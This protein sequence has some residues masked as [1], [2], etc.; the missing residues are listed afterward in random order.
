MTEGLEKLKGSRKAY[1]SHLTRIYGKLED[2]DLTK[3]PNDDTTAT[4]KSYIEQLQR[5]AESIQAIDGKI[6][7]IMEDPSEIE[8]DVLDS[9]EIQDTLIERIT[10]LK[11]YLEKTKVTTVT[12]P[13]P[14]T[15]ETT[16]RSVTASRLPKL[17][18]PKYSG[19]PLGWQTFWDSFR[20]AVHSSTHLTGI[21]KFNYLR[22]QLEGEA[23]R[24]INGLTL[25][26]DNYEQAVK[27]LESRFGKKQRIINAHMQA[28]T[29]LPTPSNSATS[30]R[31]LYDTLESHIRGLEALGKSKDTF[32]DFLIPIIF[33]RLP[34]AV[35]RNLTRDHTSEE[36][37]I[38]ELR[39]AIEKEITVLESGLDSQGDSSRST[40]SGTFLAGVR[41]GHSGQH[42]LGDKRIVSAKPV[43]VYCKGPHSSAQC[44]VVVDVKARLDV[45]KREKLCFNCLGSHRAMYCNSKNRCRLCHKK[46][47]TSLCGM[48]NP[49]ISGP[50]QQTQ[51]PQTSQP[52]QDTPI[53]SQAPQSSLNPASNSF[54]P[55]QPVAN[56]TTTAQPLL[57][58][59]HSPQ[60]LL[61][62]AI[63]LVRFGN[64][65]ISANILFDEGAQRSFVTETLASRLDA[66]PHR[67]ENL[68]IS[69][70]G[71]STSRNNQVSLINFVLETTQ[72]DVK[73]S[74]LVV[75][76]I[77]APIQ[78][79]VNS[80]LRN[81]AHLQ[82]LTLAHPVSSIEK[83]EIS[84][85]IG[86]D[87]Y[88]EI[89]GNHIVR[90]RGPTAMQSKLGYLLSGPLSAPPESITG[91]VHSYTT[92]T[93]DL[94][95]S[96]CPELLMNNCSPSCTLPQ[97]EV[98]SSEPPQSF[99]LTYQE[100][101]I[102]RDTDG[103]YIV[104]F[105]WKETHPLLPSNLAI[106]DRQTRA[107][108]RRL[109][110]QP[111]LLQLYGSIISDQEQ[112]N[113]IERAP[114]QST[115]GVHYIPHHPVRKDSPTT[116]VRIVYNC[117]CRQSPRHAS[118][119]DCLMVGDSTL[120]D[121]C[122]ILLR[123]RLHCY[124]ISTDIEKAFLHV[125]LDSR[126]RDFTRFLWLAD[127]T[128]PESPFV[129][130]RFK[131]V[132][133]GSVS[134]PFM[135]NATLDLH[136][137]SFDSPVSRDMKNNLYVDNI[138]SGCQSEK[139]ILQYYNESRAIMSGAKF[140]LRSWASNSSKLQ[141]Q[142]HKD[143]TLDADTTVNL[144][145]LKWNTC[146][147]TIYLSQC[148]ITHSPVT[149][150]SILQASSKQYDPLG[151]L[152]PITVRA[153]LLIQELW[154]RQVGWDEPLDDE[155]T[156]R[157]SQ[158]A[159]DIEAVAGIVMSRRYSVMCTDQCV[160]LHVFADAS[161]KAYGAVAYLQSAEQVDLVM[162]K[163]RVSPLKST[164]LPRLELRATVIAAHLAKYIISTIQPQ[165]NEVNIRLWSDSQITL[166]WIFSSKQLQPFV[167]NRVQEIRS[168][169]PVSVWGYCNTDDN[170]ADLLTRGITPS[171]LQSS[172]LW[173]R[174]PAWLSS[175][176]D[177][178]KWSPTS[179]LHISTDEDVEPTIPVLEIT[180]ENK[181]GV[182][183]CIDINRYSKLHKL[184]RVT[185][186]V[187]RFVNNLKAASSKVTGPLTAKELNQSQKLWIT[188]TQQEI[189]SNELI[190][191]QSSLSPRLP[192]VRQLRLYLNKEGII[193]CGGRI[194]NA[195]V[196]HSAK[197]P[198]LLPRKHKFTELIVRDAH[199]KHFHTGTNSTVTYIRQR[200]WIPAARQCVK[201]ILRHCVVCNK[202]CGN[203]YKAPNPPPLP[204]HRV[205]M[206]EPFTVTGID[207][208]GALYIR[209][210]EG[211]NKVYICL[212]TCA[213]TRAVHLEVVTDLSEETFLQAFR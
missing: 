19:D 161:M 30:L 22:G 59:K 187:L 173:F 183:Q 106:C 162:A 8:G 191:I 26:N 211:E 133:F 189:F 122:A 184:Y 194:H 104:R 166:H 148:Q 37:N 50:R 171:Q 54:I 180:T 109:S 158:V 66:K 137:K 62:T 92:Q 60:C 36:W 47:H 94:K 16:T 29:D 138:I 121:L 197:F 101:C 44:N 52:L 203:H 107:L 7:S 93:F 142:A 114:N 125:K 176:C 81:L 74:A 120:T 97:Q 103:S 159:A 31:Q 134:S 42:Q 192:L 88:W 98:I 83:F 15:T 38:D 132:L 63:A 40:I 49:P 146:T 210:P 165:L 69:S 124:A 68:S 212:F 100:N 208:T 147:D 110:H 151:W 24:T 123:F 178:P 127:P 20:A 188:A 172:S 135:L 10:R 61:K 117:S 202:L 156:S 77:A 89:V 96:N 70:F 65:R 128:N 25:T 119:N 126:D 102:S 115:G 56:Y 108:A 207:F 129:L 32:G 209:A 195:P 11:H 14:T 71:G 4:V 141:E 86:V 79:F 91:S 45:V 154:K 80:D 84:L 87:Y 170:A 99:L 193:C 186:Y 12:P 6:Q 206:M 72:G 41:K 58:V 51:P 39:S 182:N 73:I 143:H 185:A 1:R 175:E 3:P 57:D 149:K 190:N 35:R 64:K 27:L 118:L 196:S 157:W 116:P 5:K 199:E 21:E 145:G 130:Y 85:L 55:T 46:H 139:A 43:C 111:G 164:T 105:P 213:S 136:L 76:K 200:Y 179:I 177:W 198:F 163:S 152:S 150:R 33:R 53:A 112:R 204:R 131:V 75:P 167:A 205:Q 95:V 174:G 48:D 113:F 13:P 169:F 23:S 2:L 67:K 140:N 153:K 17:D 155:F 28:L 90:G 201:N 160:N 181:P 144:L 78:N 9:L 34:S 82:G 18:L 168:L